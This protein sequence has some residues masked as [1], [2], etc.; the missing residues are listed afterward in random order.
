MMKLKTACIFIGFLCINLSVSAQITADFDFL[1]SLDKPSESENFEFT[2][3]V[4]NEIEFLAANLFV[5]YKKFVSSQD[6]MSCGFHPSCSVYGS[7]A[8]KRFGFAKGMS[9]TFD[10]ISR[11]HNFNRKEYPIY[12]ENGLKYD[13]ID[14]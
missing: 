8:V 11:C 9:E 14:P 7:D 12:P 5:F 1:R 6:A 13:P 4:N 3:E 10:R 2:T